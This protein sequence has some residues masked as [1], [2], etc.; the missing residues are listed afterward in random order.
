MKK[1]LLT[2]LLGATLGLMSCANLGQSS[3]ISSSMTTVY[4]VE[5]SG[6]A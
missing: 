6:G 4:V 1:S 5:A 2:M 3:E